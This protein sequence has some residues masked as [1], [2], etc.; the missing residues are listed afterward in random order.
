VESGARKARRTAWGYTLQRDRKQVRMFRAEWAKEGAQAALTAALLE[1]DTTTTARP[2][3]T[4]GEAVDRY[5]KAK[6][7]KKTVKADG[8]YLAASP[9]C[10][11]PTR[12]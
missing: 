1:R 7:R 3:I 6:A 2:T 12:R 10:S 4:F 11:A 8:R 9:G 5:L